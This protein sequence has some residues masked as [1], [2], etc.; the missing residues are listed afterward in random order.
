MG[1]ASASRHSDLVK[2]RETF[3]QDKDEWHNSV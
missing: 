3:H 1:I 2:L